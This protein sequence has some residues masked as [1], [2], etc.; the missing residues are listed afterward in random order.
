MLDDQLRAR[1]HEEFT[2]DVFDFYGAV[3]IGRIAAEC[4]AHEG[5]HVNM[6]HVILET[7]DGIGADTHGKPGVAIVTALN[8]FTMPLIRYRLGDI[9]AFLPGP[10]A[11]GSFF[12]RIAPPLGR[13]EELIKLPSGIELTPHGFH[14]V[15]RGFGGLDQ[16]R[17][18][19]EKLD[20]FVLQLVWRNRP[21]EER[22]PEMRVRLNQFFGEPVGLD[23][24]SVESIP[25]EKLKF[26]AFISRLPKM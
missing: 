4:P 23:I 2:A 6:D 25:E 26:R 17:L 3:E 16:Y 22:I 18:I 7:I 9:C 24:Q 20:Q 11:C 10:C 13:E 19:Q 15:M 14:S 1:I 12:P 5:L 8:N 21:Q